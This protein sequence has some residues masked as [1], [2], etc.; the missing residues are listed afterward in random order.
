MSF[1]GA[2]WILAGMAMDGWRRPGRDTLIIV[3]RLLIALAAIVFGIE[4]FLHPTVLPG[5]PLVKE[6]P[7]WVPARVLIDYVTGA[8]LLVAGGSMLL[9]KTRLA[10]SSAAGFCCSCWSSMSR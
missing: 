5:V 10:P 6:M 3:G 4:H 9:K 8:A 7:A 2:G 1:G